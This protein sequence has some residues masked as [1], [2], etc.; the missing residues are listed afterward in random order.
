MSGE[1]SA[2]PAGTGTPGVGSVL[3]QTTGPSDVVGSG[4]GGTVSVGDGVG[5]GSVADGTVAVG[6]LAPGVLALGSGT[7][8]T[9]SVG[10]ALGLG[11]TLGPG[12]GVTSARAVPTI[13]PRTDAATARVTAVRPARILT[14]TICTPA[15]ERLSDDGRL[16]GHIPVHRGFAADGRRTPGHDPSSTSC[17]PR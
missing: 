11:L 10:L 13:T 1:A 4:G 7:G 17:A 12:A 8:V 15:G 14:G 2:A 9:T 3:G 5:V 16:D 6:V